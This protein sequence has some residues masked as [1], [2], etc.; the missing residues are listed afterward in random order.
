MSTLRIELVALAS[1]VF[2]CCAAPAAA[3]PLKAGD[4]AFARG[5]LAEALVQWSVAL[6]EAREA[7]EPAVEHDLLLRVATVY[8][9]LWRHAEAGD[10]LGEAEGLAATLDDPNAAGRVHTAIGL[11]AL[12]AA[13]PAR[14][15][16]H[17][18]RAFSIH[19]ANADPVGAANAALDLGLARRAQGRGKDA[20][21]AYEAALVLFRSL[22]DAVGVADA[23]TN[24]AAV[25]RRNGKLL[26]AAE[27]LS[28]AV[29]LYAKA[30]ERAGL[31]DARNN[32]G[33]VLQDLG[34]DE[35]AA[36]LYTA[37]LEEARERQDVVRQANLLRNLGTL[38]HQRSDLASAADHYRAAEQA[39]EAAGRPME[40]LSTAIARAMV[41]PPDVATL[42]VLNERAG[43]HPYLGPVTAL[44]LAL[45]LGQDERYRAQGLVE[46]A[47][48][49][50]SW[51][52]LLDVAWRVNAQQ[53]LWALEEGRVQ[54][55]IELLKSSVEGMEWTR[56]ML[57]DPSSHLFAL[58]SDDV[59]EALI[60]S[61]LE[62][63]D[64]LGALAYLERQQR[65]NG[66][67]PDLAGGNKDM[68][69][70]ERLLAELAWV[71]AS[72]TEEHLTP[73]G[74]D[75]DSER[76]LALRGRLGSMGI[77]FSDT[78][79]RLRATHPHFD[80]LVRVDPEDLQALQGELE[81]GIVVVQPIVMSDKIVLLVFRRDALVAKTV[82]V[83]SEDVEK[84]V[85]QLARSLRS[86][87]TFD[88]DWTDELCTR[89]GG[90]LVAPIADELATAEV[91][92]VSRT[93]ALRQLP[94]G[95]LRHEEQY[96]VERVPVVGVTHVGSLRRVADEAFRPD[97]ASLLLLGNPDGTLPGAEAEV[98]SLAGQFPGATTLVGRQ[99]T[100]EALLR[101]S[102][103][104]TAVHLA[105]HGV[106]DAAR[107]ARSYLA[108]YGRAADARLAYREI[109]GLAPYLRDC[110][111]VVLSACES[112]RA[113]DVGAGGEGEEAP[114]S[115]QGLA[116]QFRRA[117]VETLVG[118]LWKVDDTATLALMQTFYAELDT[119]AGIAHAMQTAQL[120]LIAD[121]EHTHPWYW[122]AFEVVGD[123]R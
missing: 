90:W 59:Y 70:Y 114:I 123:W 61:L 79:D 86:G 14:A 111:L 101:G 104:M 50:S 106:I 15:E 105:T 16:D 5:D 38:A 33:L 7:G 67:P 45:V 30:E 8:R 71:H 66:P 113:V 116:A 64:S 1:A 49:V 42:E 117:G 92:V 68:R 39:F 12:A 98:Q 107:P 88:P 46:D 21:R 6:A 99:G 69:E 122:A 37:A 27:Q 23:L 102:S 34:Q 120:S 24:L 84:T 80:D 78:V 51:K 18:S 44:N 25:D 73:D 11:L 22:D 60:V 97:G 103:G 89:L 76:I 28:E 53:G 3:G 109:P 31:A 74:P 29:D 20:V 41:D 13:D 77:E 65:S 55:G 121:P 19:K 2:L 58:G 93:G 108:L 91:L 94:F 4:V 118:T 47:G 82:Y 112:A 87:N 26:R 95:L 75:D 52:N 35:R 9:E 119:G 85:R 40:A 83:P 43:V 56:R 100:R 115:I 63:G 57:G 54:A 62:Q 96:L 10:L 72:L 32:L 36:E 110:R 81:P 17:L 48:R